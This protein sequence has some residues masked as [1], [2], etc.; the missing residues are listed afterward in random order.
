MKNG[1]T[2][3]ISSDEVY[4]PEISMKKSPPKTW[5]LDVRALISSKKW[6][7]NY[8]LKRNRLTYHTILPTIGFKQRDGKY[9]TVHLIK[10]LYCI[11]C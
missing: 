10:I 5:E 7:Q 3:V 6:L 1:A 9:L 4:N 2:N 11:T 8:G